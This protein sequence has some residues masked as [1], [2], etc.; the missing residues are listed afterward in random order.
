MF[1]GSNDFLVVWVQLA[2]EA[3]RWPNYQLY[4]CDPAGNACVGYSGMTIA[5]DGR[6]PGRE[7]VGVRFDAF[8][9][10]AREIILRL[11]EY[12]PQTGMQAVKKAFVISNP[13]RGPF[14]K[15]SPDPLPNAQSDGDLDVTL[16]KLI[17]GVQT[18][19]RQ[20]NSAADDAMNRG[21][22]IALDIQQNGHPAT[23]WQPVQ[24]QT[25]DATG[26]RVNGYVYTSSQNGEPMTFYQWGLWPDEPAW[27]LRVE[28][29]RTSGFND[30]ELWTVQGIPVENSKMQDFWNDTARGRSRPG[31]RA[32]KPKPGFAETTLN[33]IHLNIYPV[34]R[35]TDQPPESS[36]QGAFQVQLD[37]A[38]E[39]M[40]M[41][42][43]NVTD[44]QG[45]KIRS[46]RW[47]WGGNFSAFALR[48]LEDVKSINITLALHKS[49]FVE[50]TV[51]PTKP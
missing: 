30:D 48:E 28:M 14:P 39:G 29:S 9:R 6:Q 20:N 27:K 34:K 2:H 3:R 45:R 4:A 32:T 31:F 40:Q 44:D 7:I 43:V 5:S 36:Q 46:W 18:P 17:C 38:P 41:T 23:N 22:Q 50:F 24:I 49:R 11:Q 42:L 10:R 16:N 21:V 8:P 33:G 12:N 13:A 47:S 1:Q 37:P 26:N 19:W 51:K 25:F 35:F 15:W